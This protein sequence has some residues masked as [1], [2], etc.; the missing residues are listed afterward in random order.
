MDAAEAEGGAGA[1]TDERTTW[2]QHRGYLVHDIPRRG[3]E[4]KLTLGRLGLCRSGLDL[5]VRDVFL[6]AREKRRRC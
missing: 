2:S 5:A 4:V 6:E 1:A 3:W